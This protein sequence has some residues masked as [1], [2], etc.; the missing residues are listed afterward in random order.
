MRGRVPSPQCEGKDYVHIN[1]FVILYANQYILVTFDIILGAKRYSH[2]YLLRESNHPQ[3]HPP[4]METSLSIAK[5][6][7]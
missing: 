4:G 6:M 1:F 7:T 2:Y 3:S 5:V